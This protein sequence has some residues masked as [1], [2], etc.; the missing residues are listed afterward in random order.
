MEKWQ[1]QT[2]K[3]K[4]SELVKKAQGAP[5][6]ITLHGKSAVVVLSKQEFDRL[7]GRNISLVE[8]MRRSPLA[9]LADLELSRDKSPA[10]EVSF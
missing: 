8:F 1:L 4:M 5:Q 7:S 10:R 6:E 9:Q 3:A 2:A